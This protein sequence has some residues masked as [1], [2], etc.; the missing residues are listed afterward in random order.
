M[1][2][3]KSTLKD[4][5]D[6]AMKGNVLDLAIGVIIGG[7][8]GKIVSSLVNDIIMPLIGLLL[9]RVNLADLKVI[10]RPEVGVTKELTLTYGAFLQNV[11]DFL[12]IAGSV[13]LFVKL[14]S[15]FRRKEEAA[16]APEPEPDPIPRNEVLL[17]EIRDLLRE[18]NGKRS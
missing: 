9:G 10:L 16:P 15:R 11:L 12:I 18:Q 7:A 5:R 1:E 17:E 4:F 2:K 6:F 14:L 13:Y 3:L 8:F